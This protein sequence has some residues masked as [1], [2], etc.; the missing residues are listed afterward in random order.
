[1]EWLR[2]NAAPL[3]A[4]VWNEIDNIA[5]SMFKQ[6]V[7]ARRIVDFDGPR[8]WGHVATQ[9]G[10]FK[11]A[12]I[13]QQS[14]KVRF[15][16]PDVMLL[17]ELRADFSI[18]WADIDIFERVGPTLESKSIEEAAREMALA[19]DAL[20]FY[21]SST[22]PGI[23]TS[24]ETPRVA[25]SDWSQPGRLVADLLAAVEKLDTM[26]IKGPYEAVLSPHHYYSYLRQTGEGGVYPA[27]KQLG[28]VITKVHNSPT[29]DGAVL[30]STRG[31]DFMVI[32]GGDFAIGY[33]SHDDKAV[34]LFCVETIAAQTLTPEAMCLIRG[35]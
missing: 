1:M 11:P 3:S 6:T 22:N 32:V 13:Q 14:G 12:Q 4:K 29:V 7:V 34:H 33:R 19:E 23:L 9:L 25:L 17:T 18:P 5:G 2:R 24:R 30:F 27:A 10:T 35:S 15:W 26:G 20:I 31:G 16:I 28:I 21:G 8:G